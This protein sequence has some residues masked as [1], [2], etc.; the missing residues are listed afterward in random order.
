MA[1]PATDAILVLNFPKNGIRGYVG[2]GTL[3]E[4]AIALH[5][6]KRIYLLHNVSETEPY[7]TEIFAIDPIIL[8]GDI[9]KLV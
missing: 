6:G 7:S 2:P 9:K 4:I 5:L 3:F 8:D 1:D